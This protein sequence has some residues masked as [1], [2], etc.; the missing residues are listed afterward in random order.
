MSEDFKA[1]LAELT[2]EIQ[3]AY[4]GEVSLVKCERL[5]AKFLHAQMRV[6][7]QLQTKDLDA[8][9]K[10][11]GMKAVKATAYLEVA[12][13]SEKK[14]SDTYIENTINQ[15]PLVSKSQDDLDRAETD[16]DALERHYN[17]FREAHIYFRGMAKNTF[18]G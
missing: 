10:K 1:Y 5:A 4:E 14:P 9:M 13:S 16:R 2:A 7:D 6:S 12:A 8:R 18:G 17:I 3:G 11:S 15:N